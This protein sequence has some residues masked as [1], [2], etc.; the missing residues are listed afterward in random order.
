MLTVEAV[1]AT[2]VG[3][4]IVAAPCAC[5]DGA[6]AVPVLPTCAGVRT[7]GMVAWPAVLTWLDDARVRSA[8]RCRSAASAVD[9]AAA[10]AASCSARKDED[11]MTGGSGGTNE[12]I[13]DEDE[14]ED[15][16]AGDGRRAA[17][18]SRAL[19]ACAR[20][21]CSLHGT[22]TRMQQRRHKLCGQILRGG[23]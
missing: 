15:A 13:E 11:R 23:E 22:S 4:D 2:A 16:G 3:A 7:A 10:A 6:K 9:T 8:R 5:T 18:N 17:S 14:D 19:S 1:V 21:Q 20:R 12:G